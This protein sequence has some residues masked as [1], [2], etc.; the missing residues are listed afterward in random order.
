[1]KIIQNTLFDDV[2]EKQHVGI[3]FPCF[4]AREMPVGDER[5]EHIKNCVECQRLIKELDKVVYE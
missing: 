5:C 4:V 3:I 1:V 2:I